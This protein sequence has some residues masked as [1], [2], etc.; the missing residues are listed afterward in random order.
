MSNNLQTKRVSTGHIRLVL[1]TKPGEKIEWPKEI[2]GPDLL[3]H[4]RHIKAIAT[5]YKLEG[6]VLLN[7]IKFTK[8]IQPKNALGKILYL[9]SQKIIIVR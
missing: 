6:K 4:R 2:R 9:I 8:T 1:K 3:I 5:K 7:K